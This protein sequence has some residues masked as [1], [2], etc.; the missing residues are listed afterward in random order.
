[1]FKSMNGDETA[2]QNTIQMTTDYA[3]SSITE[4]AT[5]TDQAANLLKPFGSLGELILA[6]FI[7]FVIMP[8][9][10]KH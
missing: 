5:L 9:I 4:P 7:F 2:K 10:T 3:V 8:M 6:G 1:M